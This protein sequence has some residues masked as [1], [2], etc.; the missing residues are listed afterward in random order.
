MRAKQLSRMFGAFLLS[1]VLTVNTG[2]LTAYGAAENTQGTVQQTQSSDANA[3]A[4]ADT[5]QNPQEPQMPESYEWEIQS[6]KIKGWPQGP[7]VSAETAIVMDL[8]S[9]EILYAKGI[10]EKRAPASTTKIMT[11]ML[12]IEKVPLDQ[13]ITF[14]NEVNNI[15][16]GSTHIGIKPGETLT[17]EQSLYGILLASANEVSSGV[18]ENIGG[19]VQAFV[20]MMNQRAKELGC[21]NTHFVNANGLYSDDHYT[22]ARDLAIISRAAFQ[23]ETFRNIIKTE[24]YIIPPTNITAE[25]RWLNNHHKMLVSGA[26]HYD[27]CLGGKTGYTEKAGNTLVTYAERNGMRLVCVVLKDN[28]YH[29]EDTK[30]LLDYAFNNFQKVPLSSYTSLESRL[31]AFGEYLKEQGMLPEAVQDTALL[32]PSKAEEKITFKP[33]L[34]GD[35]LNMEYYYGDTLL[36]STDTAASQTIQDAQKQ[37]ELMARQTEQ[38]SAVSDSAGADPESSQDSSRGTSQSLRG[39]AA[40]LA[41]QFQELPSWKYPALVLLCGALIFYLVMLIIR[42]KRSRRRRRREKS[43]RNSRKKDE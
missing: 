22:T 4:A 14:T 41:A 12:A 1:A 35:T 31:D 5:T 3:G 43:K 32:L 40:D 29:Y 24:Y 21:E 30:N 15:E 8:D 25:Q 6:N 28:L 2:N 20:D 36:L 42:I 26:Q 9:G 11:S 34:E 13:Q 18:A 33:L 38:A 10:D 19:T 37:A 16:A 17:M 39:F 27:G 23:N 7:K